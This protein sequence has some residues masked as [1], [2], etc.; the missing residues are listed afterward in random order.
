MTKSIFRAGVDWGS[1]S[2]RAY[3][4]NDIGE[5]CDRLESQEWESSFALLEGLRTRCFDTIGDW[6]EP[7]DRVI[8]SGMITSKN[9]WVESGYLPCP[10]D[11]GTLAANA[12]L[13]KIREIHCVFLPGVSQTQPPDIMRGEELQLLGVNVDTDDYL[14]IIPGTHSKWIDMRKNSIHSFRT[15]ASGELYEV[16]IGYSLIGSFA[17]HDHWDDEAFLRAAE[18]GFN[19]KTIISELFS[20][21]SGVLMNS[22]PEHH[23]RSH[24]SGLLIGNEI[25]EG[26]TQFKSVSE[27]IVLI[28]SKSLCK[29]YQR[30]FKH[31]GIPLTV[32]QSQSAVRGYQSFMST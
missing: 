13:R 30:V 1:S 16:L 10:A 26:F 32:D 5:L 17:K 11:L 25:R 15:I 29:K 21:R 27:N 8:L 4:F 24:L 22:L 6:L 28:G 31:L 20:S 23:S 3:R 9:G 12:T 18:K 19:T 14:A 7:G 2:F